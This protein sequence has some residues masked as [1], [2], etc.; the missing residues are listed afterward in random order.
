MPENTPVHNM[1]QTGLCDVCGRAAV[2]IRINHT[3]LC[4]VCFEEYQRR[5]QDE[6]EQPERERPQAQDQER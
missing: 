3:W 4:K 1:L 6:K 5:N 2:Y